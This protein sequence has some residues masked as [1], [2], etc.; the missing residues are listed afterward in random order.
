MEAHWNPGQHFN[1]CLL[2]CIMKKVDGTCSL[3]LTVGLIKNENLPLGFC[4][5]FILRCPLSCPVPVLAIPGSWGHFRCSILHLNFI[6]LL[7]EISQITAQLSVCVCLCVSVLVALSKFLQALF[8]SLPFSV[9]LLGF[10]GFQAVQARPSA[11]RPSSLNKLSNRNSCASLKVKNETAKDEHSH[12]L[13][14]FTI[15]HSPL[16]RPSP[17]GLVV[18][19]SARTC[20]IL[21]SLD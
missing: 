1:Y 14:P 19:W 7:A 6:N 21:G 5:S 2:L 11:R 17:L 4:V 16:A 15:H 10:A 3:R 9:L 20:Q 13:L 18:F 12:S 8:G